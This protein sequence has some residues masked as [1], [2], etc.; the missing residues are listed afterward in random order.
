MIGT[1]VSTSSTTE[2]NFLLM[3]V[4]LKDDTITSNQN[5]ENAN[6]NNNHNSHTL[7]ET[8]KTEM[9]HQE[10]EDDADLMEDEAEKKMFEEMTGFKGQSNELVSFRK[11]TARCVCLIPLKEFIHFVV[12]FFVEN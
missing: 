7:N 11:S 12:K 10:D 8:N 1:N 9:N 6:A 4:T 5:I 2:Q 3:G